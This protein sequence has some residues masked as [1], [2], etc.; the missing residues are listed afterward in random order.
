MS[1]F[2]LGVE[3]TVSPVSVGRTLF[4]LQTWGQMELA[5]LVGMEAAGCC[6]MV[7]TSSRVAEVTVAYPE[8]TV[9][10]VGCP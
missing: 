3:E 5:E 4:N 10:T 2:A 6:V 8:E 1:F 7:S 9:R